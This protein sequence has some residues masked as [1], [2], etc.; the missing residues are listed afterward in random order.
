MDPNLKGWYGIWKFLTN[1]LIFLSI[2]LLSEISRCD[3]LRTSVKCQIIDFTHFP[4]YMV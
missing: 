1:S 3:V 2:S 4:M